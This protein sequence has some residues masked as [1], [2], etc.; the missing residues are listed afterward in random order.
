MSETIIKHSTTTFHVLP[1]KAGHSKSVPQQWE[2]RASPFR[3]GSI[4]G[5]MELAERVVT[6][7]RMSSV[8]LIYGV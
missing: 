4:S 2:E 7:A 3:A 5:L 6:E 8:P 1:T